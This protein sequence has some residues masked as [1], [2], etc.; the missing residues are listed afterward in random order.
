[1]KG[2][3]KI[4][5][6]RLL[7]ALVLIS[8]LFAMAV[9]LSSCSSERFDFMKENLS[10]YVK[11]SRED[12]EGYTITVGIKEPGEMELEEKIM[13]TL[14]SEKS[15]TPRY[16]GNYMTIY[17]IEAGSVVKMRYRGYTLDEMGNK[18]DMAGTSNLGDGSDATL[19]I[20]SGQ[21]VSG[22]EYSLIG[23]N[24]ADYSN[25][26]AKT[27]G[28]VNQGDIITVAFNLYMP[29]GKIASEKSVLVDTSTDAMDERYGRGFTENLIGK[30][31]GSADTFQF[32]TEFD[33]GSA[34]FAD[35]KINAKIESTVTEK[36]GTF[37]KGDTVKVKYTAKTSEGKVSEQTITV[38]VSDDHKDRYGES[39]GALVNQLIGGGNIGDTYPLSAT[40]Q[41]G[42]VYS[43]LVVVGKQVREDKPMTIKVRFPYDYKEES[44]KN[45]E[46]YFDVYVSGVC[47]YDVPELTEEFIHDTLKISDEELVAYDGNGAVEKYRSRVR[48]ELMAE[49]EE[50]KS[51]L[52][53][54]ALFDYLV[55]VATYKKLPQKELDIVK[56]GYYSEARDYYDMY[57][58]YFES[59]DDAGA[60]LYELDTPEQFKKYVQDNAERDV[61]ERLVFYYIGR[62]EGFFSDKKTAEKKYNEELERVLAEYL[63]ESGCTRDK[64]GSDAEYESDVALYREQM[65]EHYITP[66]MLYESIYYSEAMPKLLA[67][68]NIVVT[69]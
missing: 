33:Y 2:Y 62:E 9:T 4:L 1:M 6:S 24:M 45:K 25:I 31:I 7:A 27:S 5:L 29:D 50:N 23:K 69:L 36:E 13:Q 17:P 15:S 48:A 55:S 67:M 49:Y 32:I 47:F 39:L 60:L 54:E 35:V 8:M 11:I 41:S 28:V 18:I 37:V 65:L 12:Y 16:N 10:K 58:D 46:I 22:F 68:I 34:V 43:G 64:Y 51:L 63:V 57:P 20:G 42:T 19:E 53:E 14:V 40:T 26:T 44:L 61:K 30:E 56:D 52:A 38:T 59:V 66:E 3:S 21:F